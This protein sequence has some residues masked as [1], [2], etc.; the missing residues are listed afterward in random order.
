MSQ[1]T[2]EQGPL[3]TWVRS[4]LSGELDTRPIEKV[5]VPDDGAARSAKSGAEPLGN[6]PGPTL[7]GAS[8]F[9]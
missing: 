5:R 2:E 7:W 6:A 1:L 3:E 8:E 9:E 4:I